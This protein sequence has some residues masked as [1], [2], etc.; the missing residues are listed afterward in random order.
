MGV[1]VYYLLEFS[2]ALNLCTFNTKDEVVW[3]EMQ[4]IDPGD[5][6]SSSPF[7]DMISS[8]EGMN[9]HAFTSPMMAGYLKRPT[10]RSRG[11]SLSSEG[12]GGRPTGAS[13]NNHRNEHSRRGSLRTS[14]SA[15]GQGLGPDEDDNEEDDDHEK[16]RWREDS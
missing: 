13:G 1:F 4:S 7:G 10:S 16:M 6:T 12:S 9:S 5:S 11:T 15:Q 2:K 3:I 8:S 14:F